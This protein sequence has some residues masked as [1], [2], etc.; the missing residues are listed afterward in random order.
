LTNISGSFSINHTYD[1]SLRGHAARKAG[2]GPKY[3]P[4]YEDPMKDDAPLEGAL[5]KPLPEKRTF[6]EIA[7]QIRRL[8]NS[9][10]L[11]PGDKLPSENELAAQFRAGR[12]SV[13]EALRMLEQ[14]GL[15]VVRQGSTGGSYVRELDGSVAVESIIDLMWQGD[16]GTGDLTDARSAIETVILTKAFH[17]MTDESMRALD[18]SVHGLEELVASGEE[19]EYPVEP[20]LTEFHMLLARATTNP[21]FPIILKVLLEM[22]MRVMKPANANL[23]RLKRHA[24]SH[25]AVVNAMKSGDLEAALAAMEGHMIE[26]GNRHDGDGGQKKDHGS[27][28]SAETTV[29][30]WG[31]RLSR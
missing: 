23:D 6:K 1:I 11:K 19:G 18:E 14:A 21:I 29:D 9:G 8:I 27:R 17:L 30:R 24:A 22:T 12:L 28:K 15:I 16:I 31:N 20:T 25:R 3:E 13:R 7:N 2:G 10:A 5:F 4:L 26:V